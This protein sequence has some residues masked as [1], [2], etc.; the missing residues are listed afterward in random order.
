MLMVRVATLLRDKVRSLCSSLKWLLHSNRQKLGC[1]LL[2]GPR[3]YRERPCLQASV[4]TMRSHRDM[5]A[6]ALL[7]IR[8]AVDGPV[9]VG[10]G[11]G[12]GAGRRSGGQALT[13]TGCLAVERQHRRDLENLRSLA[14]RPLDVVLVSEPW[15]KSG[16]GCESRQGR[17]ARKA[18][19]A[20]LVCGKIEGCSKVAKRVAQEQTRVV[21]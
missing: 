1:R 8:L 20:S 3:H 2:T 11:A 14:S 6:E 12:T 5:V 17:F 10:D 18:V 16:S 19:G 13:G 21:L 7:T 9:D 15:R 4:E